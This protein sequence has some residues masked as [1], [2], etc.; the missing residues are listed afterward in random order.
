MPD[1]SW[2]PPFVTMV[3]FHTTFEVVFRPLAQRPEMIRLWLEYKTKARG[4]LPKNLHSPGI[5][6]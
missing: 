5:A 1:S 4:Q 6:L 3:T 2:V